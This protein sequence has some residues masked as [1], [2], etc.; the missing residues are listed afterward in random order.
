LSGEGFGAP[1]N[2]E[3][4]RLDSWKEIAAYLKRG[5]T[6]VQ[7]WERT[8]GL[9]VHRLAHAKAGSVYAFRRELDEWWAVRSAKLD[10]LEPAADD[11]PVD[12]ELPPR[13]PSRRTAAAVLAGV[14][15]LGVVAAYV[16][17]TRVPSPA[18]RRIMLAVLP[19]ENLGPKSDDEYLADGV[20]EE[21]ITALAQLNPERLAVIA[22]TSVEPYK[23]QKKPISEIA[24]ELRV[25]YVLEGSVRQTGGRMRLTAQLIETANQTH[26][27]AEA[28][29]LDLA[30]VLRSETEIA[31]AVG[32]QLSVRPL[33]RPQVR[34]KPPGAE[35]HVAYLKGLYFWNKRDEAS[36]RKAIAL[37]RQA[38]DKDPG[39]ARA[40]AGIASSY[41]LL[42]T[43]A[44]ALAAPEA[45]RLAEA[46]ARR[47]LE[48][49]PQLAEGHAALS[50]VLCRFDWA[51]SECERELREALSLDPNY[52][53]GHLWLGEHLTQRGRFA[54]AGQ[55]L[56]KAHDLD[57][58]SAIIHTH[59]GINAMYARRYDEAL[60]YYAQALEIDPRFLLAH[61]VKGLTLARAGKLEEG[62]VSLRHAR[63][64][65]PRSAHAAADLGCALARA[66]RIDEA[67][68]ILRE[69]QELARERPVS[70]YDLAVIRAG[71][72]EKQAALD[73]LEKAHF[74]RGTGVRWLKVDPIFD[75]LR[76]EPRFKALLAKVGLPE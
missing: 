26:I 10:A 76:A 40:H 16:S 12:V 21:I 23:K 72:G 60:D 58:I 35:A 47:A 31:E 43:S 38:L 34:S 8:E 52:A 71:L 29:A 11:A 70:S 13:S 54:E 62:L 59:L 67:R 49:D 14:A 9:P 39:Y 7:R 24:R 44:D 69:L 37:F 55:A 32:R 50:V 64:L 20:T 57:P 33:P 65:N 73:A 1:S 2:S 61:R 53:T 41:A 4:D 48:L 5:I 46:E 17:S 22:R 75:G 63:S 27:W 36:L 6:T 3:Q 45:R 66:G 18:G 74:E 68:A 42:A 30:N 25:D 19:F 15:L 51:W 56:A 28:Y